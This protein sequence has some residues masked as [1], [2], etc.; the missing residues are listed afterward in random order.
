[1]GPCKGPITPLQSPVKALTAFPYCPHVTHD[2][3]NPP[4]PG[5]CGVRPSPSLGK[6][7][8][9]FKNSKLIRKYKNI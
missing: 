5:P 3:I 2:R 1:M 6:W 7:V 4:A 9:M 8:D